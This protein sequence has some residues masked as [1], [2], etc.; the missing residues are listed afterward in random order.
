MKVKDFSWNELITKRLNHPLLSRCIRGLK[1]GKSGCI[2]TTLLLNLLLK[3]GWLDYDK[4]FI[5]SKS[6]FQPEYHILKT[7]FEKKAP[8]EIIKRLFKLRDESMILG[9]SPSAVIKE[10]AKNNKNILSD[11]VECNFYESAEDV[12]DPRD[13]SSENINL[14]IFDDLLLERQNKCESYYIRGRHSNVD[15]FYLSQNYFKLPCQTI[16]ENVNFICL[17]RQDLKNVNH[18]YQDHVSQ[19]KSK[20]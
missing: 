13:L 14:M 1:I 4:S 17:F 9:V 7:A 5:F 15:C 18:I 12:P 6:L 19:D 10:W 2:K 16:R 8:K 20:E 3:P 11:D